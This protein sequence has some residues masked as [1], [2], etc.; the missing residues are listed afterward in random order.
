MKKKKI[1]REVFLVTKIR[2]LLKIL[3]EHLPEKEHYLEFE[4]LY[5]E[6]LRTQC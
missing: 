5:R 3:E 2:D 6:V 1:K 4:S